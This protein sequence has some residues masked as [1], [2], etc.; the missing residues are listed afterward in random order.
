MQNAQFYVYLLCN[1]YHKR[2]K[3]N[4][5]SFKVRT[6]AHQELALLYLPH[7]TPHGASKKLSQWMRIPTL[8]TK[9]EA[10]DYL[11]G[12]RLYYPKQVAVIVEHLG[13]P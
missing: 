3:E 7:C 4:H 5:S 11:P 13:E 6:Y 10:V 12:Q 8:R 9:L 1:Q 2:M